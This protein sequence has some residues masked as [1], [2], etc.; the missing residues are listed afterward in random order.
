MPGVAVRVTW[1]FAGKLAV[2]A[3]GQLIPAGLLVTVPAPV[4]GVATVNWYDIGPVFEP[5]PEPP[6]QPARSRV[7]NKDNQK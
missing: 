1:V 2:Q 6:P 3:V 4:A 7:G 5:V